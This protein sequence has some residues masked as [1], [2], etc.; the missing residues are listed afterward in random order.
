[1]NSACQTPA[2]SYE[3]TD[4]GLVILFA[5][6]Q[7]SKNPE[8]RVFKAPILAA[9]AVLLPDLRMATYDPLHARQVGVRTGAL[10][11]VLLVL[12]STT[13]VVSLRTVGL[14]MSIAML[15]TPPATARMLTNRVGTMTLTAVGVGVLSAVGGLTASYHLGSAPGATIALVAVAT[16]TAALVATRPRRIHHRHRD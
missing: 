10:D 9:V 12:L 16:F 2:N 1:M 14:L 4:S 6:R 8:M 11:L 5:G 15:V 13:I 7:R 3:C